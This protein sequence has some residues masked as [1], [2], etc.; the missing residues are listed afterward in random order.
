M[1]DTAVGQSHNPGTLIPGMPESEV[2]KK[3]PD[4]CRTI[5]IHDSNGG[6][7]ELVFPAALDLDRPKRARTTFSPDQLYE[8][9]TEFR[10][11]QYLV[12]K[13]RTDLAKR[14]KLSETQVKVWF[15]NRRTKYKRDR[16]KDAESRDSKSESFAACNI[17]RML[18]HDTSQGT[19]PCFTHINTLLPPYH[20]YTFSG[21]S[22]T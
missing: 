9:E 16:A 19:Q 6:V 7:K 17:L 2:T 8:L 10:R 18:Q 4:Y 14:L 12:G 5:R 21:Y 13:E 22:P 3:Y 1:H 15:Q 11:N 20:P